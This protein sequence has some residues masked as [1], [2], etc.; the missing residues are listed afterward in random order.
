MTDHLHEDILLEEEQNSIPEAAPQDIRTY[1][2]SISFAKVELPRG[3]ELSAENTELFDSFLNSSIRMRGSTVPNAAQLRLAP[4]DTL[5]HHF[6]VIR[7]GSLVKM[8]IGETSA[9]SLFAALKE[10]KTLVIPRPC[11][12]EINR[13]L[14]FSIPPEPQKVVHSPFLQQNKILGYNYDE[15]L[16]LNASWHE[17]ILYFHIFDAEEA[18]RH[19]NDVLPQYLDLHWYDY[20]LDFFAKFFG[21]RREICA[22]WDNFQEKARLRSIEVRQEIQEAFQT[23]RTFINF[24]RE[25][26]PLPFASKKELDAYVERKSEREED[27]SKLWVPPPI[28]LFEQEDPK[29]LPKEPEPQQPSDQER[30][31]IISW[32]KNRYEMK[33]MQFQSKEGSNTYPQL[34]SPRKRAQQKNLNARIHNKFRKKAA[35]H[36][37]QKDFSLSGNQN[38]IS[39][40]ASYFASLAFGLAKHLQLENSDADIQAFLLGEENKLPQDFSTLFTWALDNPLHNNTKQWIAN[41]IN[42]MWESLLKQDDLTSPWSLQLAGMATRLQTLLQNNYNKNMYRRKPHRQKLRGL[43]EE[44]GAESPDVFNTIKMLYSEIATAENLPLKPGFGKKF[45][46]DDENRNLRVVIE[47]QMDYAFL[48]YMNNLTPEERDLFIGE[49]LAPK[50]Y[51][52]RTNLTRHAKEQLPKYEDPIQALLDGQLIRDFLKKSG[53]EK[54]NNI[55]AEDDDP[56]EELIDTSVKNREKQNKDAKKKKSVS[57]KDNFTEITQIES[58]KAET[59][60]NTSHS[61]KK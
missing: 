39:L 47:G 14:S 34:F 26:D 57:F 7:D 51:E 33:E 29:N 52:L 24:E 61:P 32:F 13:N 44:N 45:S 46:T 28:P 54:N 43:V 23:G 10:G 22:E 6:W 55:I 4:A 58:F 17:G 48:R 38:N 60:K 30:E 15:P 8:P 41:G 42:R 37:Y 18:Y 16:V 25:S 3:E 53:P 27:Q 20:V 36:P 49:N 59:A 2:E 1:L 21:C 19:R 50:Y 5:N 12:P 31:E 9:A 40:S 35:R 11:F 56:Q